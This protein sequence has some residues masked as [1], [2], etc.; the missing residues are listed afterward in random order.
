MSSTMLQN[1][2]ITEIEPKVLQVNWL[3][4]QYHPASNTKSDGFCNLCL[5]VANQTKAQRTK[6]KINSFVVAKI[7]YCILKQ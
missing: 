3:K 6:Q 5:S 4:K 1:Y 7:S 2:N